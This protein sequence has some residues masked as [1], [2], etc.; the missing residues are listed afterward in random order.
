[1]MTDVGP[2]PQGESLA[3]SSARRRWHRAGLLTT[4]VLVLAVVA[5]LPFA[6]RSMGAQLFGR[7]RTAR[8]DL[9]TG[10]MVTPADAERT[11]GHESFFNIAVLGIDEGAGSV[12]LGIS[13]NRVCPVACPTSRVTLFS[14]AD[15]A[16]VRQG[17]PPSATLTLNPDDLLYTE[18]LTLPIRGQPSLYPFETWALWLGLSG[19][20]VGADGT[21][22]PVTASDVERRAVI[23]IQNQSGAFQMAAPITIDPDS[24]RA[25]ADS[26]AF[27]TVQALAFT[28][29][30]Y[31]KV[32][33]VILMLLITV[34]GVLALLT[35][36]VGD[37]LIGVGGLI[38][39]IW[40]V[41]SIIVPQPVPVVTAVDLVLTL[42]I[43][44]LLLGVVIRVGR[45]LHHGSELHW[46]RRRSKS[47]RR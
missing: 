31:L 35:R 12:T 1:M 16:D 43:L 19:G 21:L 28:R 42:V 2:D 33:A 45:H 41:R 18:T 27:V 26:A 5:A 9:L 14:L 22:V 25:P 23:T 24:V 37:L 4:V 17:L 39:G 36:T 44:V 46:T 34:S 10:R 3:S 20:D 8:Y 29:P 47:L 15:D 40:G 30:D 7:E 11:A 6:A 38:L 32:L 13:G